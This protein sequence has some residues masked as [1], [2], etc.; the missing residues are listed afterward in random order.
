MSI[1][2]IISLVNYAL[3]V[4][5]GIL[6]IF[7]AIFNFIPQSLGGIMIAYGV[8]GLVPIVVNLIKKKEISLIDFSYPFIFAVIGIV[9]YFSVLDLTFVIK[10]IVL[11]VLGICLGMIIYG[12]YLIFAKK[13]ILKGILLGVLGVLLIPDA[14]LYFAI[15]TYDNGFWIVLGAFLA[16]YNLVYFIIEIRTKEEDSEITKLDEIKDDSLENNEAN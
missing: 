9:I 10:L 11:V 8:I 16:I 1:Y 2:K 5:I 13:K 15:E 14:I 4:A 3:T 7:A 6:L 12:I